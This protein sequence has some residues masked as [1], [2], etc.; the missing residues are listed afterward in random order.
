[1]GRS[2]SVDN[3]AGRATVLT[4]VHAA[5]EK[6]PARHSALTR[7]ADVL[8]DRNVLTVRNRV[9]WGPILAGTV[10]ALLSLI[11]L[12]V[13][14]L[15]IGTSAFE[16]NTNRSDWATAAGIWGGASAIAALLLGGWVAAKTAAVDGAYAGLMNG[17][18]AGAAT[19]LLLLWLSA[20]G[21]TNLFGFL[22]DNLTDISSV[23]SSAVE[24][25]T[26]GQTFDRVSDGAWGTVI[27][28]SLAL[29]AAALGGLL[30]F[31]RRHELVEGTS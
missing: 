28:L 19:I 24:P 21:V 29:A 13:L 20:T 22:S 11:L 4:D 7:N 17:L 5:P 6:P 18:M 10:T 9:Q 14:G 26:T 31:N 16:P 12:A 3:G 27:A 15:A 2:T 30:G 8:A 25:G 23:A 1:M